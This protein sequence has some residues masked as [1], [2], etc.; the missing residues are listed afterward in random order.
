MIQIRVCFKENG[1][2]FFLTEPQEES[3]A[4]NIFLELYKKFPSKD[5]YYVVAVQI[6]LMKIEMRW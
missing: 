6:K 3:F 2:V 4:R 1:N 5:G